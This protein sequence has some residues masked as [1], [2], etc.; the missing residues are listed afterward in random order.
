MAAWYSFTPALVLG[1]FLANRS[2][3]MAAVHEYAMPAWTLVFDALDAAPALPDGAHGLGL[4]TVQD[5]DLAMMII[6]H[7]GIWDLT[8]A[9]NWLLRQV[10][11][12]AARTADR[13]IA[14]RCT[15]LCAELADCYTRQAQDVPEPC[16]P[17]TGSALSRYRHTRPMFRARACQPRRS[18]RSCR[19]P[20]GR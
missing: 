10:A 1:Q 16:E 5:A 14:R 20:G 19:R 15:A 9:L 8:L 11:D 12:R 13:V 3:D 18:R 2:E 4:N 17:T 7:K 6:A